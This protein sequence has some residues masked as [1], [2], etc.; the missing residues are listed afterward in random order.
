MERMQVQALSTRTNGFGL[1]T[2]QTGPC[3]S[4]G[5]RSARI[6]TKRTHIL[7]STVAPRSDTLSSSYERPSAETYIRATNVAWDYR[8]S[9]IGQTSG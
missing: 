2:P 4:R 3:D 1:G 7:T 9:L 5:R 8:L 6:L